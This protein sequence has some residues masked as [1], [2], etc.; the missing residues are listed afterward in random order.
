[1]DVSGIITGARWQQCSRTVQR[2]EE[3]LDLLR[4]STRTDGARSRSTRSIDSNIGGRSTSTKSVDTTATTTT[5]TTTT[6]D[7]SVTGGSVYER[8]R[9]RRRAGHSR[10]RVS[11]LWCLDD[12][13]HHCEPR[14]KLTSRTSEPHRERSEVL[15]HTH[16]PEPSM[17]FAEPT[18]SA[19]PSLRPSEIIVTQA[20]GCAMRSCSTSSYASKHEARHVDGAG[21]AG[22]VGCTRDAVHGLR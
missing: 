7:S 19:S 10:A 16:A 14:H 2:L 4:A 22:G 11:T 20:S 6:M 17:R 5:T 9:G 3:Q 1:M 18:V 8:G 15:S 21:G 12:H 13:S